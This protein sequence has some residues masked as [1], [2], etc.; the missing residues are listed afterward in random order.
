MSLDHHNVTLEF[1][2]K[3]TESLRHNIDEFWESHDMD[4]GTY[5]NFARS[6]HVII[7][8]DSS[9]VPCHATSSN[10]TT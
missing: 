4:V 10:M 3:L 5:L 7:N 1:R 8:S 2:F 6:G 9:S